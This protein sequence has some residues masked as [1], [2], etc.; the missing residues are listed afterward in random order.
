MSWNCTR[1]SK[2]RERDLE[3]LVLC[4][5]VADYAYAFERCHTV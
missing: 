5:N 2:E 1:V 3:S 4:V